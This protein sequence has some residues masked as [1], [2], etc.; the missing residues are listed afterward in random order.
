[1]HYHYLTL[2]QRESLE[3]LIRSSLAGRPEVTSALARLHSPDY[4]VCE[5]CGVDIPYVR[6]SAAPLERLCRSC[7]V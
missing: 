2:E 7:R 5:R 1:M 4:G 3:R 6:L